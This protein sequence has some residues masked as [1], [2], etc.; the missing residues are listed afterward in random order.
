MQKNNFISPAKHIKKLVPYK[1]SEAF[2]T[3]LREDVFRYTHSKYVAKLDYNESSYGP[4]SKVF[5]AVKKTLK[6]YPLNWYPDPDYLELKAEI[7]KHHGK[8]VGIKNL[9]ITNGS[10]EALGV[11]S[12]TFC[13]PKDEV[14][15]ISPT[16]DF[17]R[18]SAEADGIKVR[19]FFLDKKFQ[20][21]FDK[22]K[23]AVTSKT[24]IVYLVN[25]NSPTGTIYSLKEIKEIA[26]FL[27]GKGAILIVDEA[28]IEYTNLG[29][30][31]TLL[32]KCN[33]VVVTRTFSKAYGLAN[34]RVG[35][36]ISNKEN[37]KWIEKLIP[38]FPINTI[39]EN[40]AIAAL[41]DQKYLKGVIKKIATCKKSLVNGLVGKGYQIFDSPA[42]FV[43]IK[44]K[45][46][47]AVNNL[48]AKNNIVVR[49]KKHLPPLDNFIRIT[50]GQRKDCKKIL[51]LM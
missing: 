26:N 50:I 40:A 16:Y 8:G 6:T 19:K 32:N 45:D 3:K 1:T 30:A 48:L 29:S 12:K 46:V 35:Y 41:K 10:C 34:F 28:Y 37:I 27:A 44:V 18:Y 23:R 38:D 11:I 17:L 31:T 36:L 33:N 25:P 51:S 14:L 15:I 9:V 47:D 22:F 39:S 13:N 7:A 49:P 24:K 42:S 2:R 43:L 21:N 20:F 5:S 4:S